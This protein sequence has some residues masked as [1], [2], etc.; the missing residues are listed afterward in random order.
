MATR[1]PVSWVIL[2]AV[3]AV[4]AF[5]GYH[6][7]QASSANTKETF[8][9]YS[10]E[11]A[12]YT[13]SGAPNAQLPADSTAFQPSVASLIRNAPAS[14]NASADGETQAP[15]VMKNPPIPNQM[16]NVPG[17]SEEDLRT[18]EPLQASPPAVQY[19]APEATDPMNRHV[20]MSSE[21]GSNLRH[22]E[23]MM[24]LHSRANMGGVVASGLGSEQTS[25]GGHRSVNFAPEMAQNGGEFMNGISA[26]DTSEDGVAYSML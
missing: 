18:V 14:Q 2:L 12:V 7:L 22:P 20:F 4:F 3:L 24:E 16:P 11:P 21:F 9:P 25:S 10:P 15:V 13:Q 19:D 26:F 23:Q 8:P 5:F 6:I 17:Q 1:I